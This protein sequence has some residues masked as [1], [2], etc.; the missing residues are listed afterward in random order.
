MKK[1]ILLLRFFI[2]T[3][4]FISS[5]ST[6]GQ[7]TIFNQSF[8][9]SAAA[10]V[11]GGSSTTG[12]IT[13]A[14]YYTTTGEAN[15][16]TNLTCGGNTGVTIDVNSSVAGELKVTDGS[17]SGFSLLSRTGTLTTPSP[18]AIKITFNAKF[19]VSSTGTAGRFIFQVGGGFSDTWS[20]TAGAMKEADANVFAGIVFRSQNS[21]NGATI[22]QNN[23]STQIGATNIG[24]A[25]ST[26]TIVLNNSGSS[27][28]YAAPDATTESVADN[29]YDI[30]IG[31]TKWGNDLAAVSNSA[32]ITNFKFATLASSSSG[33]ITTYL[34]DFK[35]DDL[36]TPLPVTFTSLNL[37]KSNGAVNINWG[38]ATEVN[39]EKYSVERSVDGSNYSSI[40]TVAATGSSS[41]NFTDASPASGANY[42]RIKETDFSGNYQ[43]S[44]VA[45]INLSESKTALN[46]IANPVKNGQL[47]LQMNNFSRGNYSV[48]IFTVT[49]QKMFTANLNHPGGSLT[50]TIQIPPMLNKG[51]Y[52]VQTIGNNLNL[53]KQILIQ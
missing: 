51:T 16:F 22:Y 49:G 9:A 40:G 36:T 30:W 14:D 2:L 41:Y 52:F 7:T 18:K 3:T 17:A 23:N 27:I 34:Q 39:A 35:I 44:N 12:S 42:Y 26:W 25:Y 6:W 33:V 48:S 28:S 53:N 43:Y 1:R 31:T 50:E 29:T 32:D 38:I 24:E 45:T 20:K 8:S 46:V 21:T 13:N 47:V 11:S 5:K 15:K 37:S 19:D 4:V 10:P